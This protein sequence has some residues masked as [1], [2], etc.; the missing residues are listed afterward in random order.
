MAAAL[1]KLPGV[2]KSIAVAFLFGSNT[3][4]SMEKPAYGRVTAAGDRP[5]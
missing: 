5:N 2:S 1:G 3:G 4:M